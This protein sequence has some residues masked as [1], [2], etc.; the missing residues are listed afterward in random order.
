MTSIDGGAPSGDGRGEQGGMEEGN[1]SG[2]E[3][4]REEG[5][6]LMGG[7]GEGNAPM[8]KGTGA[9]TAEDEAIP[10]VDGDVRGGEGGSAAMVAE[11]ADG[12]E[13]A[14]G[15]VRKEMAFE[16]GRREVRDGEQS[17]VGAGDGRAI[18]EG[19]S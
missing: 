15:E 8:A 10:E 16:G 4:V 13:G 18:R 19:N 7:G 1:F 6:D 2:Q 5:I 14:S 17:G 9:G 3:G 11:L 12:E